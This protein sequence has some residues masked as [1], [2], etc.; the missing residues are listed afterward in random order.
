MDYSY[1]F[2]LL[3]DARFAASLVT[4]WRGLL[5]Y[6]LFIYLFE[7]NQNVGPGDRVPAANGGAQRRT[8]NQLLFC[9]RG[10]DEAQG[11]GN[12][13]LEKSYLNFFATP[14]S[15]WLHLRS[16]RRNGMQKSLS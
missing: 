6:H 13:V 16:R 5:G 7:Q 1:L 15:N 8:A 3:M 12:S 10:P 11:D 9:R 2:V 14:P 4:P